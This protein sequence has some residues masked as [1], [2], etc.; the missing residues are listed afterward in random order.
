MI[1]KLNFMKG[2][3]L[4]T[5]KDLLKETKTL[6]TQKQMTILNVLNVEKKVTLQKTVSKKQPQNHLTNSQELESFNQKCFNLVKLFKTRLKKFLKNILKLNI[7]RLRPNLLYLSQPPLS[8]SHLSPQAP[9]SAQAKNKGLFAETFDWD[10][11]DV[12][13]KDEEVHVSALMALSEDNKLAV[14]KNHARNGE[15]VSITMRKVN[16]LLSMDDDSD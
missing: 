16:I 1:Y 12:S 10:E 14:G 9:K 3:S 5:Q 11:E 7:E 4:Q 8:L 13:S 6:Q 2:H 15:W